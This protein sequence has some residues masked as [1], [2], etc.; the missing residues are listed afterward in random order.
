MVR[1]PTPRVNFIYQDQRDCVWCHN[2][3]KMSG[4]LTIVRGYPTRFVCLQCEPK[5][6]KLRGYVGA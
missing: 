2:P 3:R 6:L 5:D 1:K 4:T